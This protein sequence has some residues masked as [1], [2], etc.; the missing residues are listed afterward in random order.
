[1]IA[2]LALAPLFLAQA[3]TGHMVEQEYETVDVAY[4]ELS[5]GDAEAAVV[6]LEAELAEHGGH[7]ALFIN[8]GSAYARLGNVDRA[9]FYYR[10]AQDCDEEYQMEL[11]D[12]RWMDS[13]DVARLALATVE[14]EALAVR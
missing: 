6:Q 4:E 3:V 11:A 10:A 12:G 7:P 2:T 8:L 5:E 9:E 1:M 14:L 13:R